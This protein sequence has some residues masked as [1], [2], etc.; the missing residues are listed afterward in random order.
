MA[1]RSD[2]VTGLGLVLRKLN[3]LADLPDAEEAVRRNLHRKWRELMSQLNGRGVA[4][5]YEQPAQRNCQS[6]SCVMI[7][8]AAEQQGRPYPSGPSDS[9]PSR[10]EAI[11]AAQEDMRTNFGEA[12]RF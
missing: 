11:L 9:S 5:S 3:E 2:I 1:D 8:A 12:I 6:S 10:Q 7:P 4:A